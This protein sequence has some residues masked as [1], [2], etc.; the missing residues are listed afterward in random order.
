MGARLHP[1]SRNFVNSLCIDDFFGT[2]L[3]GY[4]LLHASRTAAYNFDAK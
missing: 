2:S 3:S 4:A 1:A